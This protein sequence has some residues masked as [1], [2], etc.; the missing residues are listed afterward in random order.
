M[1]S[2]CDQSEEHISLDEQG[3]T[4]PQRFGIENFSLEEISNLNPFRLVLVYFY[5]NIK[6]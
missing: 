4:E 5:T 2:F 6:K 3:S 1:A